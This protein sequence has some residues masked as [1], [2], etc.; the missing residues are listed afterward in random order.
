DRHLAS[1]HQT[2]Q[3]IL[4][5]SG[6]RLRHFWPARQSRLV[7]RYLPAIC[8]SGGFED[9]VGI[10]RGTQS[11]ESDGRIRHRSSQRRR[12]GALRSRETEKWKISAGW[13][14]GI[15]CAL[16]IEPIERAPSPRTR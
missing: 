3:T 16:W 15:A 14:P 5:W 6:R 10:G 1:G 9:D 7:L 13:P 11:D 12:A 8:A 4:V 2:G